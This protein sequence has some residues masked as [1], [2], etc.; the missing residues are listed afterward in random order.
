[1]D[2]V[3][4]CQQALLLAALG[5]DARIGPQ[6]VEGGDIIQT[7]L[8]KGGDVH[9]VQPRGYQG[10]FQGIKSGTKHRL[11]VFEIHGLITADFHQLVKEF[12]AALPDLP[13]LCRICQTTLSLC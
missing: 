1:M 2:S 12:Q 3:G 7:V 8:I 13:V 9:I 10:D 11:I 6:N 5:H 4:I